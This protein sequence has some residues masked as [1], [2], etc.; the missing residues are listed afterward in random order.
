MPRPITIFSGQWADLPLE[1]LCQKA[2]DFG[3]DGIELACWGDHFDIERALSDD[4]Y[5]QRQ[6]DILEKHG[7]KC[8]AVSNHLVGQA[9]CDRIDERHESILPPE[10]WGDGKEDGIRQRAS[11]NMKNA[12]RAAARFGVPVVN[13]FTG[14]SIW[15][16]LYSFP[17]TTPEIVERGYRF[18][19]EMWNPILDVFRDEGIKFALEVHPTEIAFDI[20][21]AEKALQ[22]V[23]GRK[24][25][26]FNFDPSHLGYQGVDYIGFIRKFGDRIYHAHM[27]D[28][29]WSSRPTQAGV[30]G[31]H[32]EFG[33]PRR[34]WDFRSLGR[35]SI[36]F[37]SIIRALNEVGYQG[38]LSV[39]WEDSGMDREHGA[40]EACAFLR[41]LDFP[42]SKRAFDAAFSEG[43]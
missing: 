32:L 29:Y 35:G 5:A 16:Y 42:S 1:T 23:D 41:R 12:A 2:A 38:P 6:H 3:Y 8:F 30:F 24:E 39:E 9:V 17:T 20:V 19:A 40:R 34:F 43:R 22:A 37:E 31:G 4:S 25:F 13:G 33:D 36:D 11:E 28:V 14:S 27:K 7:L 21:T 15:G 18:F 10:I 26:G